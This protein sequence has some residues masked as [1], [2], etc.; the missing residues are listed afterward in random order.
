MIKLWTIEGTFVISLKEYPQRGTSLAVGFQC[1][2][3]NN[4]G[5]NVCY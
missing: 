5:S 2:F 1:I 3:D 4:R